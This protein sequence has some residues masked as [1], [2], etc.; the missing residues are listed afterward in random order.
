MDWQL[1]PARDIGLAP[2]ERLRSLARERGLAGLALNALWRGLLRAYLRIFHQLE[3]SGREH[4]PPPPFVL[5][6]N[7]TSH[8]D[9]LV[10]AASLRGEAA[11]SAHALAA[12]EVFFGSAAGAAFAAYAINAFPVWRGRTKRGELQLLRARL[13]EDRLVYI[14]FPEGTRSRTGAM[15]PFQPGLGM[16]VADSGVPVVP[17]RIE[18]AHAAWPP[19]RRWPRPGRLALRIGAPI[20]TAGLDREGVTAAAE[21]AIQRLSNSHDGRDGRV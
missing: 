21:A 14:L 8:L 17:C 12:G 19:Q 7:H 2:G 10:L 16:L 4:L 9:A 6:A 1:K 3:V 13:L 20:A 5:V 11:R 15:A 18:G